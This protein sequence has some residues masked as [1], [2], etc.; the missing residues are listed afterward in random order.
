MIA[1]FMDAYVRHQI[2]ILVKNGWQRRP[3]NTHYFNW[4]KRVQ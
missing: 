4:Y 3:L 2:Y 1:P